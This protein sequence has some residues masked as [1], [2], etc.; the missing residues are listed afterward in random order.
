MTKTP[1]ETRYNGLT[2]EPPD[3]TNTTPLLTIVPLAM[4]KSTKKP[5][6]DT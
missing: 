6:N 2:A 5:V 1:N 4:P 3:L